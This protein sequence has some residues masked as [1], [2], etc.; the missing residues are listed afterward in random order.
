VEKSP[1]P[2]QLEKT[3]REVLR[4]LLEMPVTPHVR[5]LRAK[6]VTY[7]RVID[8]WAVYLPTLPQMQAMLECV[9]ELHEK[10][11]ATKRDVSRVARRGGLTEGAHASRGS[12]SVTPPRMPWSAS[13]TDPA[14]GRRTLRP[15]IPRFE[16]SE[17]RFS[18]APQQ[19]E[20]TR[21]PAGTIPPVS[22]SRPLESPTPAPPF[23]RSR[24]SRG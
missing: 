23:L 12:A 7:G 6:A 3:I 15:P 21:P 14:Q 2:A 13:A 18:G 16:T 17:E 20:T 9:T 24:Q 4:E 11:F 22:S 19:R 5:E 1:R 8:R 10:V